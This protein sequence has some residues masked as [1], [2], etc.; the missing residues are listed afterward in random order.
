MKP[1]LLNGY[2]ISRIIHGIR[3]IIVGA[4]AFTC[5]S[6]IAQNKPNKTPSDDGGGGW[7]VTPNH[8]ANQINNL[9][10]YNNIEKNYTLT[11]SINNIPETAGNATI[12]DGQSITPGNNLLEEYSAKLAT[13]NIL[14]NVQ[15]QVNASDAD[16]NLFLNYYH[17]KIYATDRCNFW[18]QVENN[19]I[20][21]DAD[22]ANYAHQM[23]SAYVTLYNNFLQIRNSYP[24]SVGEYSVPRALTPQPTC[25]PACDNIDF[26]NGTLSAWE[27]YYE[28]N[29]S[30]TSTFSNAAPVGGACGAVTHAASDPNTND[31][32]VAITSGAGVD[33][34]AG[35]LIPVVCPT[36]G[37][38]SCRIGDSTRNG[39]QMGV[40]QQ[41]FTV[42]STNCNFVY[43][44]AVVLENPSHNY[45]QQPYFNV[46]MLDQNGNPIPNCG[47]YSVV[48]GPGLPGYTAIFYHHDN[49]T[50]YCKPWTTVFVPLQNY[51]GQCITIKVTA[52]DCAL[53]GHFGYAYFDAVCFSGIIASPPVICGTN[54]VTLTAPAGVT[55]YQWLGPC[56]VGPTTNQTA[57]VNCPGT[58]QVVVS[59]AAGSA[60]S[61]TISMVVPVYT[62]LTPSIVSSTNVSCFGNST[63]TA[64]ATAVNGVPPYTYSWS[65]GASGATATGLS[66][67]SYTVTVKDIYGCGSTASVTLTQPNVLTAVIS[68][69]SNVVCSGG[70]S[71]SATV[72]AGGGAGPYNYVWTPYGGNDVTANNL[73]A[74]TYTVTVSDSNNCNATVS[75]T[76]T[77]ASAVFVTAA[78]GI[79]ISCNGANNGTALASASGGTA[80]Y[81][82]NWSNAATG[83]NVSGLTAGTYTVS[84]SDMNGCPGSASLTI[85][86]PA[87]LTS[88]IATTSTSCNGG[89]NGSITVT[90]GGGTGPYNYSWSPT[91]GTAA[92]ANNL[93]AGSYTVNI[94]DAHGCP[95][96]ASATIAQPASITS[97][98]LAITNISCHGGTNGSVTITPAGGTSPYNYSWSPTGGAA[99]T[100]SNLSA[101]SYTVNI[102]DA[103]GC[104][105]SATA[106]ITQPASITSS[107]AT[108]N[109]S[110]NGGTNGSITVTTTGGTGSYNYSWLPSGGTAATAS[111]LPAGSYTV[112]ITDAH[113]CPGSASTTI[114]QPASISSSLATTNASCNG[115]TNGSVI[116]TPAGGTGPYNYSW[117]PT[118]G[119]AATASNLSAGSYTVNIT[120]AHGCQSSKIAAVNQPVILAS[121]LAIANTTCN[122][123]NNGSVTVAPT[124][125]T[126]PYNYSW[127]PTG[128]T[129]A[130]ASNLSAGSY[131]VNITDAHGC[132]SSN[133][134]MV[135]QPATISISDS[136]IPPS[137]FGTSNGSI[138]AMV[139]GGTVPYS[140]S[141]ATTPAQTSQTAT[142]LGDGNYTVNIIDAHGCSGSAS[143]ILSQPPQL[144]ASAS[145]TNATCYGAANGSAT[146]NATG[147]TGAYS[148]MWT[149]PITVNN[150]VVNVSLNITTPTAPNLGAGTYNVNVSD[151]AGCRATASANVNQ[152]LPVRIN[153]AGPDTVCSGSSVTLTASG[154]GGS[155]TYTYIWSTGATT[156][157]CSVSPTTNTTYTV[158]ASD[159][160][161]CHGDTVA[162]P[163]RS[164]M[165]TPA[166]VTVTPPQTLCAGDTV[167]IYSNVNTVNSGNVAIVWSNGFTGTGSFRVVPQTTTTY[168]VTVSNGCNNRVIDTVTVNVNPLPT[169]RIP[170]KTGAACK[171]VALNFA[172]TNQANSTSSYIWHFGDNTSSTQR[173]PS[174]QYT[175]S[176]NYTIS[177]T[178]TNQNGCSRTAYAQA[179]ITVYPTPVAAFTVSPDRVSVV[180]PVISFTDNSTY[181]T[182]WAWNFG[183]GDTSTT[184]N[185]SH[186]YQ[187][188][189]DGYRVMLITTNTYGCID[190]AWDS[191]YVVPDFRIFIP[192]AFTPNGDNDNDYFTAKGI[193]IVTF[194]MQVYDRWDNLLYTTNDINKGWDGKVKGVIAQEDTY[195]YK[196]E[197]TDIFKDP[198]SYIGAVT[199]IK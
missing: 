184:E 113:G 93:S 33:P 102:T 134:A 118:G 10:A 142:G 36:G 129:A 69:S 76:I 158:T 91:G 124:G 94:T 182:H 179:N 198:H 82:F 132:A 31:F 130:T 148:Y 40:L 159:A 156:S 39:A 45:S 161:G 18:K 108:T 166:A 176:G 107:L 23:I 90:P 175:A 46:Q 20:Q 81:V 123:G 140:Y 79:A 101:G 141:W 34:I 191:V 192:S 86:Q 149:R 138:I 173:D 73:S 196:I 120:D 52:A 54:N 163:V 133:A 186:T 67:G 181:T 50:V 85:T 21:T 183:D 64:T 110:C 43:M 15:Q 115:S 74:G 96:S 97:S 172:D 11:P 56:I 104:P 37:N 92:T 47:N 105:G 180:N 197:V 87:A 144:T 72:T 71:G 146:A 4:L 38:Y 117:S 41:T 83:A 27:A 190:S 178:V 131:T 70:N 59:S 116:V 2:L 53:G 95:G 127:S 155:G 160:N 9:I 136:A 147:G 143:F 193:G 165:L 174:H 170:S 7:E 35:A 63:G 48:S 151:Q 168:T 3:I 66:A 111:N 30:N 98:S 106:T 1:C 189:A 145:A 55:S 6:T 121:S 84:A 24:S 100:A 58:Y 77:Q 89:N 13:Y 57:V 80:P 19:Q 122:G 150:S 29:T 126:G 164:L 60:C 188:N 199:L 25:N 42:T 169:I 75:V 112:N 157:S 78:S 65:N 22:V 88:S 153:A 51:I 5:Y 125:G 61:D 137:C 194:A 62:P 167:T 32:Q 171:F 17:D 12:A 68:S 135:G 114:T 187:P 185:P 14:G 139:T 49:D 119:T 8:S 177:V 26:E 195:V 28:V 128:G 99:A 162:H 152:P 103:H 44:Y 109:I 154:T 16:F